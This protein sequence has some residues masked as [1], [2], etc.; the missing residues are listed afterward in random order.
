MDDGSQAGFGPGDIGFV[1]SGHDAWI[2]GDETFVSID[3]PNSGI[4]HRSD[5][6]V[7]R[8]H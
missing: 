6:I 7:S 1:P 2:V 3:S 8:G 5:I 4:L